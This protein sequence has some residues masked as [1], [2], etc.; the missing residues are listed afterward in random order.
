[1][2]YNSNG[3][4]L[5]WLSLTKE[6]EFTQLILLP[7]TFLLLLPECGQGSDER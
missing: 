3:Q 4:M 2:K 1:M 6:A 7:G 5:D